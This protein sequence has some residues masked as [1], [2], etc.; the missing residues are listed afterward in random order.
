MKATFIGTFHDECHTHREWAWGA[1][2]ESTRDKLPRRRIRATISPVG[3]FGKDKKKSQGSDW[4]QPG[5]M[6]SQLG[7]PSPPPGGAGPWTTG[8][9]VPV[10]LRPITDGG[11][12]GWLKGALLLSP[13]S[14]LWQPDRGVS[15]PPVELAAAA[16]V[17]WLPGQDDGGANSAFVVNLQTSAGQFQLDMDADMFEMSQQLVAEAAG[18]QGPGEVGPWNDQPLAPGS[19]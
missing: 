13:G 10:R 16:I 12:P 7:A 2:C 18:Q 17:P 3:L 9:P 6:M 4:V 19:S 1:P 8:P 14:L 15:A 11:S 5:Q